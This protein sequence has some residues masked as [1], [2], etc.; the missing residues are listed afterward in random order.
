MKKIF[1]VLIISLILT[2]ISC[3]VDKKTV[4]P[5]VDPE[6]LRFK[7]GTGFDVFAD[8][9]RTVVKAAFEKSSELDSMKIEFNGKNLS[10]LGEK[11]GRIGYYASFEGYEKTN[12]FVI[13]MSNGK[14]YKFQVLLDPLDFQVD[15]PFTIHRITPTEIPLSRPYTE[16]DELWISIVDNYIG[17]IKDIA[18]IN[19][20]RTAIIIPEYARKSL[21]VGDAKI[22]LHLLEVK[23]LKDFEGNDLFVGNMFVSYE[24]EIKLKV[25][26]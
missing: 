25:V 12:L 11:D 15:E 19:D 21:S 24:S 18:K 22:S 3:K 7:S 23:A 16:Y 17:S 4:E 14:K 9:N 10:S 6:E 13:T 1:S 8:K 2:S 26:K 5:V 20:E